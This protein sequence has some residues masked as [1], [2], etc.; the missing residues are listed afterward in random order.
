VRR[1]ARSVTS[2]DTPIGDNGAALRDLLEDQEV[3]PDTLAAL[4]E[5]Q[6]QVLILRFGLDSGTPRG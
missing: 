5:G 3:G 2:L 1:A 6:R 4:P